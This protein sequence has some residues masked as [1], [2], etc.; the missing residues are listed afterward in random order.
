MSS[1]LTVK[2]IAEDPGSYVRRHGAV[3]AE[4]GHLTQDLRK[5]VL[6]DR[7]GGKASLREDGRRGR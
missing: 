5:P 1:L 3:I 6:V 4:F 7:R 2:A